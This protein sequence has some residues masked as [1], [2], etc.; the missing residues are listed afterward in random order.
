L[1]TGN[2]THFI[3]DPALTHYEFVKK[4]NLQRQKQHPIQLTSTLPLPSAADDLAG[5]SISLL[6][7]VALPSPTVIS[8]ST[9]ASEHHNAPAGHHPSLPP[10]YN[11]VT[12]VALP[13]I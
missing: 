3:Q 8:K 2:L 10:S 5:S 4:C 1:Y 7:T 9:R 11:P 6:L 12:A 13:P